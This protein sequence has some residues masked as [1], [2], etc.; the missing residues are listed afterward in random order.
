MA[1]VISFYK[2]KILLI[3]YTSSGPVIWKVYA[4]MGKD[5]DSNK[6]K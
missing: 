1:M 4:L 6:Q 5:S 3:S 2:S